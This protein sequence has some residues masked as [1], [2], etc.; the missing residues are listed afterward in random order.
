M[1]YLSN[2]ERYYKALPLQ[3]EDGAALENGRKKKEQ[4]ASAA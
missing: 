1:I 4:E 2:A 3:N